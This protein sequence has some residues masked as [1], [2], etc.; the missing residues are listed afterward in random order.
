MLRLQH[1]NGVRRIDGSEG[2]CLLICDLILDGQ[3]LH[4][5]GGILHTVLEPGL[6]YNTT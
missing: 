4:F 2:T 6:Y 1:G 5:S 3:F